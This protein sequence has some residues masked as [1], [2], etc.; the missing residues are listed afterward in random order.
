MG[1]WIK[2]AVPS[3][4][5]ARERDWG[6]GNRESCCPYSGRH[7]GPTKSAPTFFCPLTIDSVPKHLLLF[8]ATTGYQIR[9][10]ADAARRLG[11]D[12][13]LATDRCHVLDDPWGDHA[14]PV[15]FDRIAES[16][17]ARSISCDGV[18]AVGDL[19]AVLAAEAAE[20]LGVPF[21]PPRRRGPA[22]TS[23]WRGALRAAGAGA[24]EFFRAQGSRTIRQDSRSGLTIRVF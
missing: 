8:A 3:P 15:K 6:L 18:A 13:T 9:V 12:V 24:P 14:V 5:M 16:L 1:L 10:F 22:T 20:L 2:C 21:H 19:P 4:S 23:I 11:A 7:R 17:S